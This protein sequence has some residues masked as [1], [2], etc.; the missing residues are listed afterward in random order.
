MVSQQDINVCSGCDEY[1]QLSR[2]S[3]VATGSALAAFVAAHSWLPKVAFAKDYRSTQRDVVVHIYLRG[4]AD[5]LTMCV[6][7]F[8]NEYYAKRPTIA[9]ARPDSG[10]ANRVTA[11]DDRFG[12]PP[13]M[14]GLLPAYQDGKLLVVH[15]CGSADTSRSHFQAQRVMESGKNNDLSLTTGWLGRHVA[16]SAPSDP[17]AT[18]RAVAISSA[19]PLTLNGGEKTLPIGNLDTYGITGS[20]STLAARRSALQDMYGATQDPLRAAALS[21]L[22]TIDTLNTIDFAN[23]I[24]A[25]GA[26]YPTGGSGTLPYAL[27]TS[28]ALIR[29]QV[30]V[31]AI[32]IDVGNW[33]L[34]DNLGPITGSMAS[35]MNNLAGALGAF[36]RDVVAGAGPSVS[37]VVVSE[38]G[39]RLLENG[40]FGT[41]HGMGGVMFVMGQC[42]AGGRVLTNWP[43]LAPA[44]LYQGR[45]L[46]ITIDY[47]DILAEVV[48]NR[49][50]NANLATIFPNFTPTM[51][52]VY[53]C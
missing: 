16:T 38:F 12:F 26:V 31:E 6:P 25:N 20:S 30:G 7:Y 53:S 32:S 34:H 27:K 17:N 35:N 37:V 48:Q 52:G 45:D 14:L 2:R 39:R 40:N 47:R 13:A 36:Y 11:L 41:D 29:A 10:Q 23:Y 18:L 3:F 22:Q 8:E 4:A 5:G 43:G 28:A 24:P 49:L 50:G 42:V 9:V 15:A 46:A 19:L 1:Q 33:D 44:Q 51:R 21:T